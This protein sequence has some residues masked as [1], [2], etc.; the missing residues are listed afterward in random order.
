MKFLIYVKVVV[1][2]S[3]IIVSLPMVIF[4]VH[5][6]LKFFFSLFAV[7]WSSFVS[8]G[9]IKNKFDN[10]KIFLMMYPIGL[11]YFFLFVELLS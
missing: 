7:C 8:F 9:F 6:V 4:K 11:L 1:S 5:R 10:N 3:F 2:L